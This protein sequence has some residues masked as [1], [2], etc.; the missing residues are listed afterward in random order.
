MDITKLTETELKALAFDED[1]KI[2]LAQANL[3]AIFVQLEKLLAEEPK[4]KGEGK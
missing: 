1:Q 4:K 2:K 3:Q